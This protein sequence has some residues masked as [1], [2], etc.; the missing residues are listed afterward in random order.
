M[1]QEILDIGFDVEEAN[2]GGVVVESVTNRDKLE[3]FNVEACEGDER[4]APV[5][6]GRI[7]YGALSH[8]HL[9]QILK[10]IAAAAVADIPEVCDAQGKLSVEKMRSG[11]PAFA[12]AVDNGLT[13]EVL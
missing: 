13:W 7:R 12:H 5:V 9:N 1:L 3:R 10:N 4:L 6:M 8:N 2:M 11:H